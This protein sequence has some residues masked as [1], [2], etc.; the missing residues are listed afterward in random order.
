[1]ERSAA[2][3]RPFYAYVPY[4]LVQF[5]TL[6]SA[7]FKGETCNGDWADCLAQIDHNVGR[8]LDTVDHW[9]HLESR[10]IRRLLL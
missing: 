7:E 9:G 6:P 5:P 8:L 3:K 4:T 10:L 1:M 2:A